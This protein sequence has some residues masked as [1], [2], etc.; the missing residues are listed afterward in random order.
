M[1]PGCARKRSASWAADAAHYA[2]TRNNT[3]K[4]V[5]EAKRSGQR[6]DATSDS[7]MPRA[8]YAKLIAL[9]SGA[10]WRCHVLIGSTG[11]VSGGGG[12]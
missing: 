6:F 8:A 1:I 9:C 5:K 10:C 11:V 3:S 7:I 2:R 4:Y 12:A